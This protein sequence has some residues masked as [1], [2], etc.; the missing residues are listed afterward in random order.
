MPSR[1]G[2]SFGR[3]TAEV[4]AI[5]GSIL[6]AFAIDAWWD[7]SLERELE[8]EQL[9]R[10]HAE[11]SKNLDSMDDP[12]YQG[13]RPDAIRDVLD[14]ASSRFNDAP[15]EVDV[16]VLYMR[17]LLNAPT[18]EIESPV[19]DGLIRAGGLG[20]IED[21]EVI[22]ALASWERGAQNYFELAQRARR[23][24]DL[25]LFPAL[26]A[27]GNMMRVLSEETTTYDREAFLTGAPDMDDTVR[28]RF[29]AELLGLLAQGF[30]NSRS[31]RFTLRMMQRNAKGVIDAIEATGMV[32]PEE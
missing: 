14:L 9:Q 11:F 7:E 32:A 31:A 30:D 23:N 10:L 5:V 21:R 22:S 24:N 3:T 15:V 6:V 17:R 2:I 13:L 29:D 1:S 12:Y 27:R 20:I 25:L 16:P 26:A 19:L 8:S 28:I 4:V 18:F